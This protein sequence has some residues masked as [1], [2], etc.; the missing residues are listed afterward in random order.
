MTL[1]SAAEQ[2]YMFQHTWRQIQDKFYNP[3]FH[4]IDWDAMKSAYEIKLPTIL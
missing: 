2:D 1:R 4:G 3:D